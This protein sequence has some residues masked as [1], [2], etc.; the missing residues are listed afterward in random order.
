[1]SKKIQGTGRLVPT[2]LTGVE[3]KVNYGIDS[4]QEVAA[5]HGGGWGAAKG[6]HWTKCSVRSAH[7]HPIPDGSYF[8]HGDDGRVVQMKS[9]NGQWQ[10]LA[11]I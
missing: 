11:M 4:P 5:K 1:M 6:G 9:Q 7:H 8:L 10:Y 2:R 3:N